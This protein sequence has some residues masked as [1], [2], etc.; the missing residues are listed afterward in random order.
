MNKGLGLGLIFTCEEESEDSIIDAGLWLAW[1]VLSNSYKDDVAAAAA[2]STGLEFFSSVV[3]G[4][5]GHPLLS[6]PD[7]SPGLIDS[8]C[9]SSSSGGSHHYHGGL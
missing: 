7:L 1:D 8:P 5:T 9:F 2:A 4:Q 3:V 6:Y